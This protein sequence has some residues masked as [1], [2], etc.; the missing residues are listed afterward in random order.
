[1]RL[2]SQPARRRTLDGYGSYTQ[3]LEPLGQTPEAVGRTPEPLR[4]TIWLQRFEEAAPLLDWV[5]EQAPRFAKGLSGIRLP[6]VDL[7]I[8]L[9]FNQNVQ[10]GFANRSARRPQEVSE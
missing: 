1:V 7:I 9:C 4:Q 2:S 10:Q 3:R 6:G 8:N 5:R